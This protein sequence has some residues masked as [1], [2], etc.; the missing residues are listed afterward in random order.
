MSAHVV[1]LSIRGM[2]HCRKQRR[3]ET[4]EKEEE[5]VIVVNHCRKLIITVAIQIVNGSLIR[6][7]RKRRRRRI[8][9]G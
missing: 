3:A 6:K 5:E 7:G 2:L 8:K 1:A 4:V 9:R